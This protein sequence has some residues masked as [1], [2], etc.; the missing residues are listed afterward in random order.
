MSCPYFKEGY[1][2][3]CGASVSRYIPRIERMETY[4]FKQRLTDSARLYRNIYTKIIWLWLTV[5]Q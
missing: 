1:I 5:L 2:G 3:T 4:C